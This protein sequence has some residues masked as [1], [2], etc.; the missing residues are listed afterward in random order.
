MKKSQ[1]RKIVLKKRDLFNIKNKKINFQ[2]LLKLLNHKSKNK[3]IGSIIQLDLKYVQ[4][5]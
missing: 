1:I 3:K 5:V 2:N 4:L